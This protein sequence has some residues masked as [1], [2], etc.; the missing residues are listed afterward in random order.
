GA[1]DVD[2]LPFSVDVVDNAGR[3]HHLLAEGPGPRVDH[4]VCV[5]ARVVDLSDPAVHGLDVEAGHADPGPRLV[6]VGPE[7]HLVHA[8][9]LSPLVPSA[10]RVPSARQA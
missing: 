1:V 4:E 6:A 8:C 9:P 10:Y 7:I 5:P 2:P 3:E